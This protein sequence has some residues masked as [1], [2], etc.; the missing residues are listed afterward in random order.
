MGPD[1]AA[2]GSQRG[3]AGAWLKGGRSIGIAPASSVKPEQRKGD[4]FE[5][6]GR[7]SD[8]PSAKK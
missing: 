6:N 1:G 7:G 8:F 3:S 4:G 5:R 2:A